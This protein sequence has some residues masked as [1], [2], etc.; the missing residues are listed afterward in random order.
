MNANPIRIST[1]NFNRDTEIKDQKDIS[2]DESSMSR[3]V[4]GRGGAREEG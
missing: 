1:H 2:R 3:Q 4:V